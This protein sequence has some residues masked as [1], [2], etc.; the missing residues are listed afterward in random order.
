MDPPMMG[1]RFI[2]LGG[3]SFV[4]TRGPKEETQPYPDQQTSSSPLTR[5]KLLVHEA[6]FPFLQ[7]LPEVDRHGY[8]FHTSIDRC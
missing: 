5:T 8:E 3:Y 4:G 7:N 2:S 6:S 1:K